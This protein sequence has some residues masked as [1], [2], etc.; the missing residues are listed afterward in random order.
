MLSRDAT[1]AE[2]ARLLRIYGWRQRYLSEEHSTV[3]RLDEIQAALLSAKLP[4]LDAWN[5]R[6]RELAAQYVSELA[7]VVET[8]PPE[9]VF[10][11]FVIRTP[12]RDA[13]KAFLAER[14]IGT[15]IH[16]PFP[17]HEQPPFAQFARGP[18]PETE[19][20]AREVLSLPL[21]PELSESD[22]DYVAQQVRGFFG[23]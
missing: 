10:H 17:V 1:V 14:G 3:S 11:L 19:R 13:L 18:L 5:A 7:G 15:D 9:G 4:H 12:R 22:V 6:R 8:L 2:R 21:Y 16:Y 23:A 20:L